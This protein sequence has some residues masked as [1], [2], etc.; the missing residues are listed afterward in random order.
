M[1]T[2]FW[3]LPKMIRFSNSLRSDNMWIWVWIRQEI[4]LPKRHIFLCGNKQMESVELYDFLAS[5]K[6]PFT[7]LSRAHP[8][9]FDK[10]LEGEFL[11]VTSLGRFYRN[12]HC[13]S[14]A[15]FPSLRARLVNSYLSKDENRI[16]GP[17]A[18]DS[19]DRIFGILSLANDSDE[20]KIY[21]T[22]PSLVQQYTQKQQ[23]NWSCKEI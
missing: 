6:Q 3:N 22:T 11:P 13:H 5:I 12:I 19:R 17:K 7:W 20:L 14:H 18:S 1:Y 2:T 4:I 8:T 21:P 16:S 15:P 23:W 9:D 10:R